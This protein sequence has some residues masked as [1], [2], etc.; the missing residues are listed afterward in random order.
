MEPLSTSSRILGEALTFDDVLLVPDY[1]EVHPS[2]TDVSTRLTNKIK[3]SIPLLAAAMAP[4]P[5]VTR[6]YYPGLR[7]IIGPSD[8]PSFAY[9]ERL[10]EGMGQFVAGAFDV[11]RFELTEASFSM[12][13]DEPYELHPAQRAPHFDSTDPNYVAVLH[14][15]TVPGASGTAFFRQ[16]STGIEQV[17]EANVARFVRTAKAES[18]HQAADAGYIQGSDPH[19]EMI[20]RI[21]AVPDRL[22]IFRGS[23]L[24]SGIIP[25]DMNRSA[26]PRVG[27]LTANIFIR[28]L[29][30]DLR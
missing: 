24:D 30:G 28:L 7:R 4:F 27:R 23:L 12:V 9:V 22:L 5:N 3:L 1:S 16:R 26:D 29:Q 18:R 21:D 15:L 2:A 11:D 19:F 17:T 10:L 13:T 25:P 14:Y 20:D 8:G 6:G